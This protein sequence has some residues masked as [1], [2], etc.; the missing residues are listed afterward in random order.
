MRARAIDGRENHD[1]ELKLK[2]LELIKY[3][4]QLDELDDTLEEKRANEMPNAAS[5]P[6]QM[7]RKWSNQWPYY[8]CGCA[9]E[10]K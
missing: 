7:R 4:P 1:N 8:L 2:A 3:L 9:R 10:Q 5:R 6:D